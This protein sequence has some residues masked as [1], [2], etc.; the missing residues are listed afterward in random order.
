[1]LRNDQFF[2]LLLVAALLL[3]ACQPLVAPD[4]A[5]PPA[6]RPQRRVYRTAARLLRS[7]ASFST[8]R[9]TAKASRCFS[10]P[11]TCVRLKMSPI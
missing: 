9:F 6:R 2:F 1:M 11:A 10:C 5:L 3:N 8:T 7:M 4:S